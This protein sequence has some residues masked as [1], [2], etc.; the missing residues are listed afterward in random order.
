MEEYQT[1]RNKKK[2]KVY[3]KRQYE[4]NEVQETERLMNQNQIRKFYNEINRI[5]KNY[6]P[7]LTLCKGEAGQAI[8]VKEEILILKPTE[9]PIGAGIAQSV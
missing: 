1:V 2:E 4:N 3:S 7:L 6:K 5:R 9:Q 8:S